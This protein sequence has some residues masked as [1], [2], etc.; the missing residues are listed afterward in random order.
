ME[1]RIYRSWNVGLFA[2][3]ARTAATLADARN[4]CIS[5]PKK[6]VTKLHFDWGHALADQLQR[7]LEESEGGNSH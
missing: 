3:S 5:D 2:F 6:N 4:D 1:D 7:V